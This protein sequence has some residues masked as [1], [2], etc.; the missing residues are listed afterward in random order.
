MIVY[1]PHGEDILAQ[2][3]ELFEKEHPEIDVQYFDM[4]S[5]EVLDRIRSERENPQS[6]IWWGAPSTMFMNAAKEGLMQPYQPKWADAVDG[7][8]KDPNHLWYG[9]FLTPEVIGYNNQRLKESEVPKDWDELLQPKWKDKIIIRQPLASG[10]MYEKSHE[11]N[12][13]LDGDTYYYE[14]NNTMEGVS[15]TY[16]TTWNYMVY[17]SLFNNSNNYSING[18]ESETAGSWTRFA[19]NPLINVSYGGD[20]PD[21]LKCAEPD[22]VHNI[23]STY[24]KQIEDDATNNNVIYYTSVNT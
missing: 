20:L 9:T 15:I 21:S 4:G 16:N 2:F 1:S 22:W 7:A 18:A 8:Y 23:S 12:F 5:Q 19:N 17:G 14:Q 3:E 13:Q 24:R 11:V 10:T 6:D